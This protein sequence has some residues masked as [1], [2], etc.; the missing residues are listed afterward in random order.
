MGLGLHLLLLCSPHNLGPLVLPGRP[1]ARPAGM[2]LGPGSSPFL[3]FGEWSLPQLFW[4]QGYA[5]AL[6]RSNSSKQPQ[7]VF[8]TGSG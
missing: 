4:K 3:I 8:D 6:A 2:P 1:D 7:K 5:C